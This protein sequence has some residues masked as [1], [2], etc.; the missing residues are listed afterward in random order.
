MRGD[1]GG[2]DA[3]LSAA[4]ARARQLRERNSLQENA[5]EPD[6]GDVLDLDGTGELNDLHR[7][8]RALE[9]LLSTEKSTRIR[10]EQTLKH[11]NEMLRK[12][13]QQVDKNSTDIAVAV[14][15]A[16]GPQK[17]LT[18]HERTMADF[19]HETERVAGRLDDACSRLAML[20]E[21]SIQ[22]EHIGSSVNDHFELHHAPLLDHLTDLIEDMQVRLDETD[23]KFK[24][25]VL[26]RNEFAKDQQQKRMSA[27]KQLAKMVHN[28][29]LAQIVRLDMSEIKAAVT[30]AVKSTV[31]EVKATVDEVK[32]SIPSIVA[33]VKASLPIGLTSSSSVP[34]TFDKGER[35]NTAANQMT[36][37]QSRPLQTGPTVPANADLTTPS[38]APIQGQQGQQSMSQTQKENRE[39]D[40]PPPPMSTMR[41]VSGRLA[42]LKNRTAAKPT[43]APRVSTADRL[44]ALKDQTAAT[45]ADRLA[46]LK[47]QTAATQVDRSKTEAS[48]LKAE[49]EAQLRQDRLAA[50][51]DQTAATQV[52]RSKTEASRL[53]AEEEA[54]LRQ[55]LGPPGAGKSTPA[56]HQ[57]STNDVQTPAA[58]VVNQQSAE[59]ADFLQLEA[60]AQAEAEKSV[61][62][63]VIA[64][65]HEAGTS[66]DE[67]EGM[68]PKDRIAGEHTDVSKL[69]LAN[70]FS[71]SVIFAEYRKTLD[72]VKD[73]RAKSI[74]RTVQKIEAQPEEKQQP[75]D[76]LAALI[77]DPEVRTHFEIGSAAEAKGDTKA[78]T[79]AYKQGI[80]KLTAQLKEIPDKKVPEARQLQVVI[81][82]YKEKLGF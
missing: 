23:D 41:T 3:S 67:E 4:R 46:A 68:S 37:E 12:L 55:L 27:E 61:D 65:A 35:G 8:V 75:G 19:L 53:K 42:A 22:H 81:D 49:E 24:D 52:D 39:R 20:E 74:V 51:K 17:W 21:S 44:A 29:C 57:Q 76:E 2:T 30:N 13:T 43:V 69:V 80:K 14:H 59:I 10:I 11:T 62:E 36:Q 48:R 77:K 60:Q 58:P 15:A 1:E 38:A 64:V 26:W 78:M 25:N 31:D 70:W 82:K 33:E 45:T 6:D 56:K 66:N 47:D 9:R 73:S 63:Q 16:R 71:L 5:V 79:K 72:A 34:Q 50:L 40:P 54:Q 18:E 28:E 32:G 7:Q